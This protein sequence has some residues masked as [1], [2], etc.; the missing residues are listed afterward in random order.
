MRADLFTGRNQVAWW[1]RGVSSLNSECRYEF[2]GVVDEALYR[3]HVAQSK[4]TYR[5][6][7]YVLF[8][9][10]DRPLSGIYVTQLG[11]T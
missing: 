11:I 6:S 8:T 10:I 3:I 2:T 5:I 4:I 1:F 7:R 9:E